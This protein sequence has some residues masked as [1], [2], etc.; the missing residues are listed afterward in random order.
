MR[1]EVPNIQESPGTHAT[2]WKYLNVILNVRTAAE[3]KFG[4]WGLTLGKCECDLKWCQLCL[5]GGAGPGGE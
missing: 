1:R 4:P 2:L 5:G 3:A